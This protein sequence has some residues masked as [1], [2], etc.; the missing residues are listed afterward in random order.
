MLPDIPASWRDA[1]GAEV[2][3]PYFSS[4]Q[5]FLDE[6]QKSFEVYPETANIFAALELTPYKDVKVL[7]LGQDPYPGEGQAHGLAFS[8]QP[9][10]AHPPSLRNIYKELHTDVG[11]QIPERNG[12]LVPWAKQGILMLNTVLTVRAGKIFSHKGKGWEIFTDAIISKVNEKRSPVVF[13]LWGNPAQK[14]IKL[15]DTERHHVVA[16]AHPSPLAAKK[17]FGCKPFSQ[18]NQ[19]LHDDGK[20]EINW[21]LPLAS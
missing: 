11:F 14:K 12:Y 9:G 21:Q 17:F 15:I 1:L 20:P 2:E 18:I 5:K 6:E 13:V 19:F 16:C 8:V 10:I 3:K 7:L 4:L